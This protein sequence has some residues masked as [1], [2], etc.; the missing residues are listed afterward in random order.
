MLPSTISCETW[1]E[2]E[3]RLLEAEAPCNRGVGV[4]ELMLVI[5]TTLHAAST[6]VNLLG[7]VPA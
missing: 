2:W 7:V 4:G 6:H 3:I 5:D 1:E